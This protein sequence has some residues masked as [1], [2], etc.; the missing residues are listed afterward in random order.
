MKDQHDDWMIPQSEKRFLL[1]L[2]YNGSNSVLFVNGS[3]IY[4]FKAKVS[5]IKD[6]AR[7]LG[8]ILRDCTINN[9]KKKTGLKGTL[10][11]FSVD[12]NDILD[13]HRYLM[14][15]NV[16]WNNAWNY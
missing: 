15:K 9:M 11:V 1:S 3:K 5:E 6:Y 4:Q 10:K 14:K 12:T 16:I 2:H 13:I 7:Y 8:N